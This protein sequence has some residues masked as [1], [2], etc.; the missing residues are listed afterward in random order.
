ML[1]ETIENISDP[2]RVFMAAAD[3]P[4]P[5]ILENSADTFDRQYNEAQ[6]SAAQERFTLV[7]F[8]P[9]II[10]KAWQDS[11][12]IMQGK[13]KEKMRG[14][15]FS[16]L[17]SILCRYKIYHKNMQHLPCG[18][19]VGYFGYDLKNL[20][21]DLPPIKT[22]TSDIPDLLIGLYD[23]VFVYDH[24]ACKGYIISTGMP[25]QKHGDQKRL[26][27]KRL[28]EFK[29]VINDNR[30]QTSNRQLTTDTMLFSSNFTRGDYIDAVNKAKL[31]ISSGDIYQVNLS[32]RFFIPFTE[33][34]KSFYSKLRKL[35][36]VPFGSFID[37]GEFQ[38]ISNSP[39]C[40]L[41][42]RGDVIETF[43]I[44]GTRPRGESEAGDKAMIE[45][46]KKS[47]KE[48]AEHIMIVDLERN[49]LG[50]V[51]ISGTVKV[52]EFEKIV[53]YPTLHHMVS[54]VTGRIS[55]GISPIECIKACFPGGSVTG[56]PKVR[57]M[58]IIDELEPTSR[59]IYTGAIGYIDFCGNA[60]LG[61]AIRTAVVSNNEMQLNVGGGIV[62][63]SVPE[64]EYEETLLK[65]EAFFKTL[66]MRLDFKGSRSI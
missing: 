49:D 7:G 45:G 43:P 64:D 53:T 34:P 39:E 8:D 29:K 41:K 63:D 18:G 4:Y 38:V 56:A 57:A 52:S 20:L 47:S 33:D 60:E 42:I 17:D 27:E 23:M 61:M 24:H 58:E 35:H 2:F 14:N 48:L 15:P 37:Y 50:K 30:G 6:C 26:A 22:P 3:K 28:K 62:A 13:A 44:K 40:F 11:V 19:A 55:E 10:I 36:P 46:L 65:A 5:F 51:C 32:Q 66:K 9:F 59:G 21:E 16:I 31:Y 25:E 54:S 1:I 12:E